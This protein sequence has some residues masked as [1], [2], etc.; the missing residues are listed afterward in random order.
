MMQQ[1]EAQKVDDGF[2]GPYTCRTPHFMSTPILPKIARKHRWRCRLDAFQNITNLC[3]LY[4]V[5]DI[6]CCSR[7]EYEDERRSITCSCVVQVMAARNRPPRANLAK[8]DLADEVQLWHSIVDKIRRCGAI[9][10]QYEDVAAEML[11]NEEKLS[12]DDDS[13]SRQARPFARTEA[14]S[15]DGTLC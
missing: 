10:K 4:E 5:S 3:S 9:H 1:P 14:R 2:Q 6:V 7:G 13:K 8:E 12:A 11:I 15:P